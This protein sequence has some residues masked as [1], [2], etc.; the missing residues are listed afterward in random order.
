M[1]TPLAPAVRQVSQSFVALATGE[2]I[3]RLVAFGGMVYLARTLG[4]ESY[5]IV[6]FAMAVTLYLSRVAD[7]GM[8]FIGM[9]IQ[10]IA[11]EPERRDALVPSV[12]TVRLLA[13][14]LCVLVLGALAP[15]L[16]S[17]DGRV[18]VLYGLTL[19]AVAIGTRW[20]YLGLQL[21]WPVAV[22]RTAGEVLAVVLLLLFVHG[23]GDVTRAPLA[24]LTGDGV[25][26]LLLLRGLL[27]R[28]WRLPGRVDW[29]MVRPVF[30]RAAPLVAS[31]L[32]GLLIYNADLV[33]L[34]FL[35]DA[36][37]VGYYAAAYALIS[38]LLNLGSAYTQS[39]LPELARPGE[40][41]ARQRLYQTGMAQ[42]LAV[43]API[44]VGGC[45]LAAPIIGLVFGAEYAASTAPLQLLLWS[46]PL[47]LA[48]SVGTTSL[49]VSGSRSAIFWLTAAAALLNIVLN[50]L[51]IPPLGI[52]GAAVA[53]LITEGVRLL[54]TLYA[55][56]RSGFGLLRAV[57]VGRIVLAAGV[58]GGVL[59]MAGPSLWLG[60]PLGAVTYGLA[61]LLLG[62]LSLR[63]PEAPGLT[64]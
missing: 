58:M 53:T 14:S 1:T 34:R 19:L 7:G 4:A 42:V 38:F 22:A 18:L 15:L 52:A 5:G 6:G 29:P 41:E 20:V 28:G 12:L 46:I 23:A 31:A 24:Q 63:G 27:R 2:A 54:L 60:V 9:G 36:V 39:L 59:V 13:A 51:L 26:A 40:A 62:G 43:S 33:M 32:L 44:A 3:A 11:E 57:R 16:P 55:A 35:R 61:L 8:E 56:H 49:V 64:V 48:R 17:P 50:L 10:M 45:Y 47:G 37:A 30:R 21:P 25:A